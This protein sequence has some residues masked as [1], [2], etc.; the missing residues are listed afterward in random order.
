MSTCVLERVYHLEQSFVLGLVLGRSLQNQQREY[1]RGEWHTGTRRETRRGIH[2]R[3]GNRHIEQ[4]LPPWAFH[5]RRGVAGVDDRT[6]ESLYAHG[7]HIH[8]VARLD[9]PFRWQR[10]RYHFVVKLQHSS[11]YARRVGGRHGAGVRVQQG[12]EQHSCA[13]RQRQVVILCKSTGLPN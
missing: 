11:E 3:V 2:L 9:P 12:K 8:L 1:D 7:R 6:P 5:H 10:R 4:R 13:T